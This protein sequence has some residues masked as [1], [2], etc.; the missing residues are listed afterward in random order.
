MATEIERTKGHYEVQKTSYG[1]AYIWCPGC[2]VVECDCG[3]KLILT[4]SESICR[5]G[6]DHG[7]LVP[8]NTASR[9][10]P[11]EAP[12]PWEAE[13]RE[14]REKQEEYLRSESHHWLE[15]TVIE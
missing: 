3:E 6:A 8:E 2:A 1:E 10:P 9:Q 11:D 15:W 5:C 4:A 13:Y 14:W 12:H 7:A